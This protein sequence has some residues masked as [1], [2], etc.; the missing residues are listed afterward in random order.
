MHWHPWLWYPTYH[1]LVEADRPLGYW[2]LGEETGA[3]IFVNLG[4]LGAAIDGRSSG[5]VV[6]GVPSLIASPGD[7]AALLSPDGVIS[8]PPFEKF[9]KGSGFSVEFWIQLTAPPAGGYQNIVG[10]GEAGNDFNFMVYLGAGRV[11]AHLQTQKG[12]RA[13]DSTRILK[14]GEVVHVVSTWDRTSGDLKLYLNGSPA[15]TTVSIGELPDAGTP[16]HTD[17]GL[18]F[19]GDKRGSPS[20]TAVLDEVAIYDYPL[21]VDRIAEHAKAGG[22]DAEVS[23]DWDDALESLPYPYLSRDSELFEVKAL[24]TADELARRLATPASIHAVATRAPEIF[25]VLA[26]GDFRQPREVVA[27]GG[28]ACVSVAD[29][30]ALS[31]RFGLPPDAPEGERRIRL[32]RWISD[33][34]NPLLARVIVN[35][36]WQYHFG[37]GLVRTPNDF[38]A[39]GDRPSHPALLDWLALRLIEGGW[40]LKPLH[41]LIVTSATYRQRSRSRAN[42]TAI[43]GE[44][45]LLWRMNPRRLEAEAVRDSVL[46]V[47]GRLNPRVGGSSYSAHDVTRRGESHIFTTREVTRRFQRRSIYRMWVR[48]GTSNFLEAF[49]CPN[50]SV[51]TPKRV[52]TTT[53]LQALTLLNSGFMD[54]Q[55][56]ALANRVGRLVGD[57]FRERV[58]TAYRLVLQRPPDPKELELAKDFVREEGLREFCLVL[59]NSSEFLYVD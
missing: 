3:D 17:N 59:L 31:D 30:K 12:I 53:P 23:G 29:E 58:A 13:I 10:D 16:V 43:D 15:E 25:R 2:R 56:E 11:R 49:D 36:L 40:R 51:R 7:R 5:S 9:Q 14:K 45:R 27:P 48:S 57:T 46:A 50:T 44:N 6:R 52:V 42:A 21:K 18:F 32:A 38:G 47:A 54:R 33:S 28:I 39:N 22:I 34:R 55:S 1:E 35:R 20:P 8:V 19:G 41:E 37:A 4:T 26:R 24:L